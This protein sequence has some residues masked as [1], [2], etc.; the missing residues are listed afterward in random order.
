M[1]ILAVAMMKRPHGR[2]LLKEWHHHLPILEERRIGAAVVEGAATM[3][4]W[5]EP[6]DPASTRPM[7]QASTQSFFYN[8][9]CSLVSKSFAWR[10]KQIIESYA[11]SS[12]MTF[13]RREEEPLAACESMTIMLLHGKDVGRRCGGTESALTLCDSKIFQ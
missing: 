4:A 11:E 9:R 2:E 8:Q 7:R 5:R 12:F 6:Q 3:H 10:K 1:F 13:A